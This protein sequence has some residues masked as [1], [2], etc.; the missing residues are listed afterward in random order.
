MAPTSGSLQKICCRQTGAALWALA[1][2][3]LVRPLPALAEST[4]F[5]LHGKKYNCM[6]QPYTVS[7]ALLASGRATTAATPRCQSAKTSQAR[8]PGG[9]A[10]KDRE[11]VRVRNN[12][13]R[14]PCL[15]E[16]SPFVEEDLEVDRIAGKIVVA[17]LSKCTD[18]GDGFNPVSL[19][20]K[21]YEEDCKR[22]LRLLSEYKP[23]GVVLGEAHPGKQPEW[24]WW[25]W[26]LE[27]LI[28]T[29]VQFCSFQNDTSHL[30][31]RAVF[32]PNTTDS[33]L[34][35]HCQEP[36]CPFP[37]VVI[38]TTFTLHPSPEWGCPVVQLRAPC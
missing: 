25:P 13:S 8:A 10:E 1:L 12:D 14:D 5:L 4:A 32:C 30:R 37:A 3:L 33:V 7:V 9:W 31:F 28:Q 6:G 34:Q 17:Q 18:D 22:R 16:G 20:F 21:M 36:F 23:A 2:L 15:M 19:R 38:S 35:L 26:E 11:L 29:E 27:M 24:H